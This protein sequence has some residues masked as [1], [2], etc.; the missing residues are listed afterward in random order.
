[1]KP[2]FRNPQLI[3]LYAL[4]LTLSAGS[5]AQAAD[6]TPVWTNQFNGTGNS[7][8]VATAVVVDASGNV[9][10]TGRTLNGSFNYATIKYSNAGVPLWTNIFGRSLGANNQAIAVG[11]DASGNILVTGY[12]TGSGNDWATLKLSSAGAPVWTNYFG[13]S[14]FEDDQPYALAVDGNGDVIVTGVANYTASGQNYTTVKYSSTGAKLWTNVYS[15]T[16]TTLNDVA[17]AMAVDAGG[18]VYVT[19]ESRRTVF[20]SSVVTIKYTSAGVPVWTN[21]FNGSGS[22]VTIGASLALDANSNIYVAGNIYAGI[23]YG[24]AGQQ[25]FLALKYSNAGVILWTNTIDGPQHGSDFATAVGADRNGNA[26]VTGYARDLTTTYD[27]LTIK[28]FSNG[29][30]AW[31]NTYASAAAGGDV[32]SALAVDGDGNV[33]VTGYSGGGG[34]SAENMTTVK[35]SN[36]GALLWVHAFNGTANLDDE[37]HALA[38]DT[39]GNVFVTGFGN[40]TGSGVDC[41]TI[42][43]SGSG[44]GSGGSPFYI[45]TTNAA[46]GLSNGFFGFNIVGPSGSNTIIEASSNLQTWI[47]LHTNPL[48][49][50]ITYFSDP[51]PPVLPHRF[52]HAL[53]LP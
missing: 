26:F 5:S 6:G 32:P 36:S 14:A 16:L 11:A 34:P 21:I 8:D 45:V 49:G 43:Y 3:L 13:G 52:Y 51:Q 53:L 35:Y 17:H 9:I 12:A 4:T 25:D 33:I 7:A 41:V 22:G 23:G 38:V 31:T 37:G 24:G 10:V 44:D 42:K 47:P 30:P 46:F 40:F 1:M 20:D 15:G 29:T 50:G 28:Y 48:P 2:S 18:N 19:G 27:Y 39:N